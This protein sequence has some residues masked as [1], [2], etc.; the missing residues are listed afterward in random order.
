M[1]S[2]YF[3]INYDFKGGMG[4]KKKI[5]QNKTTNKKLYWK[6]G[7]SLNNVENNAKNEE[8]KMTK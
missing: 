2:L 4:L 5:K 3:R 6:N 1:S 7:N 8:T